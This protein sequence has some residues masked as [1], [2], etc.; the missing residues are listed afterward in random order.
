M[1]ECPAGVELSV[2][3]GNLRCKSCGHQCM[4]RWLK[5][6]IADLEDRIE[7]LESQVS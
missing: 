1:G 3:L 5:K 2:A 6:E 7:D 4:I